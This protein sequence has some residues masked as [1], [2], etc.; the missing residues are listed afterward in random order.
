MTPFF[1]NIWREYLDLGYR[2]IDFE[3]EEMLMQ[4]FGFRIISTEFTIL[5]RIKLI[6]LLIPTKILN[7]Y[8]E[9]L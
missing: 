9:Y 1:N 7:H 5:K 2:L 6:I 4:A 8:Q 3:R